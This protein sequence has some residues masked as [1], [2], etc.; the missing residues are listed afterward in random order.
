MCIMR[1]K[2]AKCIGYMVRK[3]TLEHT[4]TMGKIDGNKAELGK[5]LTVIGG[6]AA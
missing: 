5:E 1:K 6:L 4:V 3:R 2:E